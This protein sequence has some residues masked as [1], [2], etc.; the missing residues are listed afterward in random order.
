MS[1]DRAEYEDTNVE[2]IALKEKGGRQ[3][4]MP[5]HHSAEQYLREYLD[6]AGLWRKK[7]TPLFG[8]ID[9][10]RELTERRLQR[11]EALAM[12][13]RRAR[14]AGV[15]EAIGNHTFR[16]TGITTYMQNGGTLEKAQQMAAHAS[17][18]TTNMYNRAEDEVTLDEVERVRI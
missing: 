4:Q 7:G 8:T 9:V 5:L 11:R 3:H 13:K 15:S 2:W 6:T 12:I 17:S 18:R 10:H 1:G 14:Q 16:A